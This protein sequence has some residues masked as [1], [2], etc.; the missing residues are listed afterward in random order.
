MKGNCTLFYKKE[1]LEMKLGK[2]NSFLY[3]ILITVCIVMMIVYIIWLIKEVF[4]LDDNMSAKWKIFKG[5]VQDKWTD[6]KDWV[7]SK[8][9]GN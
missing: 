6:L 7:N 8:K 5:K 3:G 1:D 4:K 9:G 2:I